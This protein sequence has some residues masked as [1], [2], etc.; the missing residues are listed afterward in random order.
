[1]RLHSILVALAAVSLAVETAWAQQPPTAQT[2]PSADTSQQAAPSGKGEK[3]PE[4]VIT[5]E[6]QTQKKKKAPHKALAKGPPAPGAPSPEAATSAG[7]QTAVN[8]A[9]S[10]LAVDTKALD[11]ARGNLLTQIGTNS[12]SM[13]QETLEA[14]PQ[15]TNAPVDK[16][17]LQAPGVSQDS[18][19]SGSL[20]VRNDHA[21]LQY[22]INGIIL[23]DGVS[24]FG[25]VLETGFIGNISLI[26]GALPA[27]YGLH[28]TGLVDIQ[29]RSGAFNNGGSVGVYGGSRDELT[30]SFEYGGT[31]G[32]TEYFVTS[33]YFQSDEGIENPAS[34]VVPIHDNT[35]QGGFFSYVSTLLDPNTRLSWISGSTIN[36]FQIPNNPGQ[37]PM[38]TAFGMS[39]FNSSLLNENQF[40]QN[41]YDVLALQKKTDNADVQLAYFARYSDLHFTPDILGDLEFNGVSSN[42]QRQSLVNG[43]QGDGSYRLNDINTVRAGF[44][45]SGEQTQDTNFSL[46][47]P[48]APSA[49]CSPDPTVAC[50]RS[51]QVSK[52]GW[53][54]GFYLQ[55][56]WKI[57]SQLTLNV[58]IRFD[59]MYQFVDANQF[60]PRV[61]LVYKPFEGTTLHAGYARYFTPPPQIVA[62]PTNVAAF[63]NTTQAS[64]TCGGACS[65][66]L[67][68]RVARALALFR[69]R[70]CPESSARPRYRSRWLLQT[71]A[72]P[73][74]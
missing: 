2:P 43:V 32:H 23:P 37:P 22:R 46:V 45:V 12:F 68:R 34:S 15:G 5:Q 33:R 53:L 51:D 42:V 56:E 36:Q 29:T 10:A 13:S 52:L 62:G 26:T 18:A 70:G 38:F 72:R 71:R 24:G 31:E 7:A 25:P 65:A 4:V 54:L 27:E 40:E 48:T 66:G 9:A 60:S 1:M 64:R 39:N 73:A 35:E 59:Q 74:R 58:G 61:S 49:Q 28:T 17:L 67:R 8:A 55:D 20:H 57:T 44:F 47:L 6:S 14:L 69:R 3:L 16:V 41:Y 21:N 11:V 63:D 30:P 19:A 50:P